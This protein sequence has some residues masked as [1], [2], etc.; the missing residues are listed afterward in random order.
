M[1]LHNYVKAVHMKNVYFF[2]TYSLKMKDLESLLFLSQF[3]RLFSSSDKL[4]QVKYHS[5]YI[6][7]LHFAL[8]LTQMATY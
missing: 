6:Q 3:S 7:M 8:I 4:S 2:I 1:V 5:T